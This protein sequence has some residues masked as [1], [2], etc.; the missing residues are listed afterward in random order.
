MYVDIGQPGHFRVPRIHAPD[1][2]PERDLPATL[3]LGVIEVIVPLRVRAEFGIVLVRRQ[4]QRSATAPSANQLGGD[5][6]TFFLS[7]SVRSEESIESADARLI[8]AQA[9]VGA[10]ATENVRLRHR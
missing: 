4:S 9:N 8:F 1:M 10:V 3:I 5:Q 7:A 2:S 6:L